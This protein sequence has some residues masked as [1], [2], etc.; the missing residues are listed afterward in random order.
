M[1]RHGL[2]EDAVLVLGGAV[3]IAAA[4]MIYWQAGVIVA[5]LV[6]MILAIVAYRHHDH[7]RSQEHPAPIE[8]PGAAAWRFPM[9]E[10]N[11]ASGTRHKNGIG[12]HR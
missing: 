4:W 6:C 10:H 12:I 11:D 8:F 7:H 1:S 5:G 2:M 3:V 9:V